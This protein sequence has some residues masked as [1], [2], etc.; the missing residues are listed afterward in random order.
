[1]RPDNRK[2]LGPKILYIPYKWF[3]PLTPLKKKLEKS[4]REKNPSKGHPRARTLAEFKEKFPDQ[5]FHNM[6]IT[7]EALSSDP[8]ARLKTQIPMHS[9][10]WRCPKIVRHSDPIS[11]LIS[12]IEI[13]FEL[14][15]KS[16]GKII[17]YRITKNVPKQATV[18]LY[19]LDDFL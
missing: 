15:C 12:T 7:W 5:V 6:Q 16:H 3:A 17:Q 9:I 14:G 10:S 11:L 2:H 8:C 18:L 1:M 19:F 4:R 13:H